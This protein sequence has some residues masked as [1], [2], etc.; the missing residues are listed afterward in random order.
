MTYRFDLHMHS[1]LSPCADLGNSPAALAKAAK[2]AGLNGVMLSDHNSSRNSQAFALACQR[3]GIE[4]LFGMEITTA[5]EFHVLA[6]FDTLAQAE[7]MTEIITATLPKRVNQ[8]LIFGDQFVVN[9]DDEIE[10]Q[11]W[12]LLSAPTSLM[13]QEIEKRV[14]DLNGLLIACHINRP[15]FSVFS[16]L[17]G[18]SGDEGF[19]AVELSRNAAKTDWN[20]KIHGLPILRSSDAHNLSMI[21]LIWNEAELEAF[22]VQDLRDA[23]AHH[24]ITNP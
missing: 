17:G 22:T 15:C 24:T 3:E 20:N 4:A 9:I 18:L 2:A 10:E 23:L 6:V 13:I 12:H 16:Q 14:H 7:Q 19:D 5:E 11:E 1:C 8:P 21:G